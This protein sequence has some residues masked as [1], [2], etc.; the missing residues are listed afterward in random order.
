MFISSG[1]VG[2]GIVVL[3]GYRMKLKAELDKLHLGAGSSEAIE[4][5]REEFRQTVAR[6]SAEIDEMSERLDFT[7]R[8]LTQG[9]LPREELNT[10]TS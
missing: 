10:P 9:N 7:E 4:E 6:Q 1:A 8:L 2:I 3:A 5:L